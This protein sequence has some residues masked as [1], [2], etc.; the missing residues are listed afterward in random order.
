MKIFSFLKQGLREPEWT[1]NAPGN[2]W[3]IQFSQSGQL[4]GECRD[5]ELKTVSFFCLDENTGSVHWQGVRLNQSAAKEDAPRLV[6]TSVDPWWIG[7]DSVYRDVIL[8]HEFA[9]PGLPE[10][11]GILALDLGSGSLLWH[12]RD[13]TF[14]FAYKDSL[15]AYK[16][17]FQKRIGYK[18]SLKTGNVEEE[19]DDALDNLYTLRSLALNEQREEEYLFPEVLEEGVGGQDVRAIVKKETR[20]AEVLGNVE[21]IRHDPFLLLNYYTS[22]RLSTVESPIL[23]NRFSIFHLERQN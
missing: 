14:W 3:R 20:D 23:E 8:L 6:E 12:N 21:F 11:R 16:P 7:I 15:Y 17:M 2:I 9:N 5:H 18:L 19:F 22:N 1:Y 4:V 13:L 10:H